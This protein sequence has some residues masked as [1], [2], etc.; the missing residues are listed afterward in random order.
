M[1]RRIYNRVKKTKKG[2]SIIETA[3]CVPF[4][5]F[6]LFATLDFSLVVSASLDTMAV[7]RDTLRSMSFVKAG[8]KN[9]IVRSGQGTLNSFWGSISSPF[10]NQG[11][12]PN[13]DSGNDDLNS[14]LLVQTCGVVNTTT[15]QIWG[16]KKTNICVSYFMIRQR[17]TSRR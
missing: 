2:Q 14:P 3:I 13:I 11:Q 1:I 6:I 9:G 17:K 10:V 4:F 12:R 7:A 16:K 15:P 8:S 5:V